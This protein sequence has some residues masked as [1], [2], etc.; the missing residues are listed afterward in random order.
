MIVLTHTV[1]DYWYIPIT[2][3]NYLSAFGLY[4]AVVNNRTGYSKT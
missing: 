1:L 4:S 2:D 3:Q